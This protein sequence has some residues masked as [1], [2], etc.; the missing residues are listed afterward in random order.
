MYSGPRNLNPMGQFNTPQRVTSPLKYNDG[1]NNL[2][3]T[4]KVEA[5]FNTGQILSP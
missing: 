5:A 1:E 2:G 4:R 3:S